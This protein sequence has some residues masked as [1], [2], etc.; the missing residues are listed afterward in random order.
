MGVLLVCFCCHY[1]FCFEED[2]TLVV[3]DAVVLACFSCFLSGCLLNLL[4]ILSS[5]SLVAPF[6]KSRGSKL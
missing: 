2:L 5:T 1:G 3:F 6:K 4:L